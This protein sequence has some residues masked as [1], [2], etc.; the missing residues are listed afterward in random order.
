MITSLS[1]LTLSIDQDLV[2][3]RNNVP[4]ESLIEFRSL[5]KA[6]VDLE[7]RFDQA[8]KAFEPPL[9]KRKIAINKF[10]SNITLTQ[11]EWRMVF[12]GMAD[13]NDSEL[14]I[15]DN[16][17]L[18]E[19]VHV[20]VNERIK[21]QKLNRRDWLALCFSYFG[22]QSNEPGAN[23]NWCL[24]RQDITQGLNAVKLRLIKERAWMR[25]VDHNNELFTDQAGHQLAEQMFNSEIKDLSTLQTIAQIPD[26]SWLWQRIFTVIISR[27]F[28]LTDEEF[29]QR[30]TG[31]IELGIIH[32]RFKTQILSAC[33]TRYHQSIYRDHTHPFLKQTAMDTWG[34]PQIRSKQNSWLQYVEQP[35]CAMVVT[36][37]AKEDLEHFF[38]LLKGDSD[39]DQ[40]RLFY[41][42]RFANQMTY[43]RIVMGTDALYSRGRD[44][45][46]FR[47]KNNGRFSELAGA[48]GT[49][50]AVIMQI[51]DYYFV[52]FSQTGNACYF[53]RANHTPFNPD[54]K[55][56]HLGSELKKGSQRWRHAPA[57]SRPNIVQGWLKNFDAELRELGIYPKESNSNILNNP[58]FRGKSLTTAIYSSFKE[59]KNTAATNLQ[60]DVLKHNV[61][62]ALKNVQYEL[63]DKRNNG[64]ALLV[65]LKSDSLEAKTALRRLAFKQIDNSLVFYRND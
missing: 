28:N 31:L 22:Y 33:L 36:W 32:T 11:S 62:E 2:K 52:E 23:P 17:K 60:S 54:K 10:K 37:F 27:I 50:N 53:Y 18:F 49:N 47:E 57:P 3:Y 39:V 12:A 56:L 16:D 8:E 13:Q 4:R 38:T 30:I 7:K 65:S 46:E 61:S 43:T 63:I 6:N 48:A 14:T 1:K 45:V 25:I 35:V 24:L 20:E 55:I 64:G 59:E 44:F 58:A 21:T 51:G 29:L 40:S 9:E 42:L 19:R 15:L 41:W 26:S 34:S 5:C